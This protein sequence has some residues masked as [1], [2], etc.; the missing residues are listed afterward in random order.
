MKNVIQQRQE[1]QKQEQKYN[2]NK[3]TNQEQHDLN[4]IKKVD[5]KYR[6][7]LLK[8]STNQNQNKFTKKRIIK[9][10]VISNST[11]YK[12]DSSDSC[13]NNVGGNNKDKYY[14]Q[15]IANYYKATA[16]KSNTYHHFY[17]GSSGKCNKQQGKTSAAIAITS[18]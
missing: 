11:N 8:L 10:T 4:S 12:N 16:R 7:P 6:T 3:K 17:N 13:L 2:L 15:K 14:Q 18:K 9:T 1:L 5:K